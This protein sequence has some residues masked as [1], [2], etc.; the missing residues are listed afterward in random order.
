MTLTNAGDTLRVR[1]VR[2][3]ETSLDGLPLLLESDHL[4]LEAFR[5]PIVFETLAFSTLA[6]QLRSLAFQP[7]DFF[8]LTGHL[9]PLHFQLHGISSQFLLLLFDKFGIPLAAI[10][11][12][13]FLGNNALPLL[14]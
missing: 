13:F 3:F 7:V 12:T 14:P 5:L 4:K 1:L 11:V 10:S 6:L 2:I 9:L 8:L